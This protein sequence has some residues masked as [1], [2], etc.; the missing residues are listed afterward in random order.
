[1]DSSRLPGKVLM[2]IQGKPIL[3]HVVDFLRFSKLTDI[4]IVATTDLPAD[5]KIEELSNYIDI[6]CYR[7]SSN[8]VLG[9]YYEC[10][11]SFKAD[12]IT[13]ITADNPLLDPTIIDEAIHICKETG[14][15]YVTNLIN[16]TY[17]VGYSIE[18]L[19]FSIL[20][21]IHE[22]QNDT[23]SREHVTY[24]MRQ[25][26]NLYNI[27]EIFAPP[28]LIRPHW[29]LTVDYEEDFR[30]ISKIF[31]NLYRPHSF[32][33]YSSLVEFLDKNKDLLKIN[34]KYS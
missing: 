4:I 19:T 21:K 10:S 8:D 6:D 3:E 11:K 7:G 20:K 13:R 9:R 12:V 33:K 16:P 34:E 17:P 32:I 25:N 29:R 22:T 15:D 23:R 30:L 14:C 2:K 28:D 1:M 5:D 31:S 18:V 27:K 26:P 24:H